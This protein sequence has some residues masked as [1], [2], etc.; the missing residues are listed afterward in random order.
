MPMGHSMRKSV[1]HQYKDMAIGVSIVSSQS[2]V[3]QH[4]SCTC[5]FLQCYGGNSLR[6]PYGVGGRKLR[7]VRAK[8]VAPDETGS[9]EAST[10]T[11]DSARSNGAQVQDQLPEDRSEAITEVIRLLQKERDRILQTKDRCGLD[12]HLPGGIAPLPPWESSAG[13][14]VEN[15]GPGPHGDSETTCRL[16]TI[17]TIMKV[18]ILPAVTGFGCMTQRDHLLRPGSGQ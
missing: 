16:A 11:G 7:N 6:E 14:T 3:S 12:T 18:R 10:L 15:W 1:Q 13:K 17:P 5:R 9:K 2:A 8:Y 4:C